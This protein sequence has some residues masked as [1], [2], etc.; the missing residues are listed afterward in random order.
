MDLFFLR[1]GEAEPRAASDAQRRLTRS[2]EGDVLAVIE[3]RR[4]ELAGLELI[5]TSPYRRA[6][7]TAKIAAQALDFEPKLL[8]SEHLEPGAE[9]QALLR[10]IDSL[11]AESIL[12]VTHQ[13]LVGNV[14]SLLSGD[15]IWLA[16]GTANLVA[17]QTQAPV[18]GFADVRWAQIPD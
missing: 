11:A 17:L 18:P 5:V 6:R 4:S 9:P 15:N 14:L 8:V 10:F 7:Q 12:L 2:G 13:P 3:S 1:H 16:T